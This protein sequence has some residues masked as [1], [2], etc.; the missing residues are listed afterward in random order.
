MSFKSVNAE[1][2]PAGHRIDLR[3]EFE[4]GISYSGIQ[5][6][7]RNV[8]YPIHP[9][10]GVLVADVDLTSITENV[11][12]DKGL[13]DNQIYFYSLYPYVN[14]P[15]EFDLDNACEVSALSTSPSG[16]SNEMYEQLPEIYRRYDKQNQFLKR[17]M[18]VVGGQFDQ[19]ESYTR[20]LREVHDVNKTSDI[21]LPVVGDWIGWKTDFKRQ[22][23]Q[24]REEIK[25][26]PAI[27]QSVGLLPVVEATIKRI[28]DL[29]SQTKE[30]V[31]NI[32][33][34]NQP[35]KLNY[36]SMQRN[37]I[38][39]WLEQESLLSLDYGFDGKTST[40]VDNNGLRWFFYHTERKGQWEIWSKTTPQYRMDI[41]LASD[42]ANGILAERWYAAL[43]EANLSVLQTATVN[44]LSANVWQIDDGS[45]QYL[46]EDQIDRIQV[47]HLT[48]GVTSLGA[49][50]PSVPGSSNYIYKYPSAMQYGDDLWLFWSTCDETDPVN[51]QWIIQ[52]KTRNDARWSE[53]GPMISGAADTTRNPFISAGNYDHSVQRRYPQTVLD[54]SDRLW[55]FWLEKFNKR[56]QLRY[57]RHDGTDWGEPITFPLDT[58]NDPDVMRDLQVLIDPSLGSPRILVFWS[59]QAEIS[60]PGITRWEV[61]YRIK[62]DINFDDLNWSSIN[63]LPKD[64][65]DDNHHDREAYPALT[66]TGLEVFWSSNRLD[67]GWSI[68][69]GVITDTV[70][71]TWNQ[72]QRVSSVNYSQRSPMAIPIINRIWLVYHS[73][74]QRNYDSQTYRATQTVDRRYTGTISVDLRHLQRIQQHGQESDYQTYTYDTGNNGVRDDR[75]RI[76]RDTVGVFLQS[77][78]YTDEEVNVEIERLR[79]VVQEFFPITDRAVFIPYSD[80]HT[81]YVYSY[82]RTSSTSAHYITETY[83][84]EFVSALSESALDGGEDFSDSLGGSS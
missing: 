21:M 78:S 45:E 68:W 53:V 57:N 13:Y 54:D 42:L 82:D 9:G 3:W 46:I 49:S 63:K 69:S 44:Q 55:L 48:G 8:T 81:E 52:F 1:P 24:Q 2:H 50:S 11:V 73:N 39:V 37:T 67:S 26:A 33:I 22:V 23:I 27:Y 84:D 17:F 71:N 4:Q 25:N 70:A 7:R 5:V 79:P 59:R 66:S 19:I 34:S 30:Y 29:E 56:W 58:G 72:I 20:F 35:E 47:Y 43:T 14:D 61:V 65:I 10:D 60:V 80:Y 28:S 40:T 64:V 74:R 51:P 16:H 32:A 12:A 36:W 18:D 75:H 15:P 62:T 76:A 31:H 77:E 6:L 83:V 41:E 38:G